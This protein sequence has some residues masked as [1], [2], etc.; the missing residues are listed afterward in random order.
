MKTITIDPVRH[1]AHLEPG[2]TWGEV[3]ETLQPFGL[4]AGLY[5]QSK[6]D[7][8][9]LLL[10]L[11]VSVFLLALLPGHFLYFGYF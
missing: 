11:G 1:I 9:N 10:S 5:D 7:T 6:L 4:A 3:A 2:L 8:P